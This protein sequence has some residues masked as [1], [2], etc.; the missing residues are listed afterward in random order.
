MTKQPAKTK[1]NIKDAA[2]FDAAMRRSCEVTPRR[3]N[4]PLHALT[5]LNNTT[6]LEAAHSLA[7]AACQSKPGD[8]EKRGTFLF[9]RVVSRNPSEL[10]V[11]ILAREYQ[12]A[13]TYYQE[14]PDQ[15]AALAHVGQLSSPTDS[16]QLPEFA[17]TKS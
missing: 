9:L 14:H 15:A 6:S 4:T 11:E 13:L 5:L 7:D 16:D 10:E 17:A 1:A 3:T 2:L 12:R 8:L